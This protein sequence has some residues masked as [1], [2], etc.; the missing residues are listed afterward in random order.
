MFEYPNEYNH[1]PEGYNVQIWG[2]K[3]DWVATKG[4]SHNFYGV[5]KLSA[6]LFIIG[7]QR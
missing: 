1:K 5:T 2:G 4:T 3:V 6:E 7:L